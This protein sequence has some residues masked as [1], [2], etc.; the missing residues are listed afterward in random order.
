MRRSFVTILAVLASAC[1][2]SANAP[3]AS[4]AVP[5]A[6]VAASA[7]PAPAAT[8]AAPAA[9]ETADQAMARLY[10][11]AKAEGTVLLYSSLNT[12]D[13][14]K[15]LPVFE[16]KF[17]GIKVQ[18]TRASGEALIQKIVTE[19]KAGQDLFDLVETN[20]F[21]IKFIMDQGYTQK[22]AVASAGDFPAEVRS[23]ND[24]YV[25]GRLNNDLPGINTAKLPPGTVIK[26][27]RDLCDK[28]FEGHLAVEQ[29]DVVIYSAFK[30]IFGEAEAQSLLKCIAANKPS[31]RSGHTEMANLLAA[32]EFW[33]T[34]ASNGHR[35]AQLRNDD[36]R[37]IDWVRTDPV[38]TDVQ[39][40]V[41]ANKPKNPNAAKL[42]MEWFTSP[43]GQAAIA[44]TGRVPASGKGAKFP[45]LFNFA[46]A[47]YISTDLA[48]TFDKDAEFWR[49]TFGIK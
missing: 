24:S 35:L 46:K 23:P 30:K 33:V 49:A 37:P 32:G 11:S 38:I 17:P 45:E 10:A 20:L 18:H 44:A 43:G 29:G 7:A 16:A 40:M 2:G 12:D 47:F 31:L 26:T 14:K 34:L 39:G 22:Y 36:K 13:A 9:K 48:A 27:W 1:G 6:S 15:I 21:E 41:L 8:T 25:A 19:K 4:A 3:A 28:K 5:A 42:F